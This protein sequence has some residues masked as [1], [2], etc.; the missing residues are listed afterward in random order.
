MK[1]RELNKLLIKTFPNLNSEYH[2]EVDWQEGD[3]TGSHTVYGDVFTPYIV[4]C[5]ENNRQNQLNCIFGF[6]EFLL[7]KNDLYTNEVIAF[8]VLESIGYLIKD[9]KP[10]LEMLGEKTKILLN[11]V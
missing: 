5:I 1:S 11:E 2:E 3:D 7:L 4:N 9:N 10:L 8:S 6:L